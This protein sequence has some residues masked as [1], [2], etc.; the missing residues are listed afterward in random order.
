[1]TDRAADMAPDERMR[2]A[3]VLLAGAVVIGLFFVVFGGW[4]ALAPLKSAAIA[5]GVVAVESNRKTI[6]HL[7]G[8]IVAEIDV[9]DGDVVKAG[10]ILIRLDDTQAR[11]TLQRL[12]GRMVA[13][14]A[15]AARLIAERDG[16]DS[17]G[18]PPE[19]T[20]ADVREANAETL[21]GQE[22]IFQA[23]RNALVAQKR[24]LEQQ[25]VQLEEEIAGLRGQIKSEDTQLALIGSELKDVQQ[26]VNKKLAK[27]ARLLALQRRSAEIEGSR[28]RNIAAVARAKQQIAETR[29]RVTELG[30]QQ[31]NKVVEEL[32]DV[33]TEL[34]D[35]EERIHSAEDVL[36]RTNIRAPVDGTIVGL[37]IHT[38]GGVIGPGEPLMDL[39]PSGSGMIIEA[40]VDPNDIDVVHAGL[41]AQVRLSAFNRRTFVPIDGKVLTISADRL[42][43]ERTGI[44]YFL[45]RVV[46]V[47]DLSKDVAVALYPGMQAEVMIVTGERTVFDY[48]FRPFMRSL[49]RA[50][51]ED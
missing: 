10:Q 11:V 45:A 51:R 23:R 16:S 3:P 15:L 31:L 32:R 42:T 28:S 41:P 46:L 7:E 18:F 25:A 33:Q 40:R 4:A 13:A 36:V 6:K 37:Q 1:M 47:E 48:I 9:E 30:T 5:Q 29:L 39:V 12:R 49:G 21:G 44:P 24:I 22:N 2:I 50:F 26:L 17:I 14:R 43:D 27:R 35:L 8:G 19:L 34:F 20:A 38:P